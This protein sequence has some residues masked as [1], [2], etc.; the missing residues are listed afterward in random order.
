MTLQCAA[1]CH[2]RGLSGR[3]APL[4]RHA[5]AHFGAQLVDQ[6]QAF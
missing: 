4:F 3:R 5:G 6:A 2:Q 1:G